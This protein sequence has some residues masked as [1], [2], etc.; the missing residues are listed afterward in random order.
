MSD[1]TGMTLT[2]NGALAYQTSSNPFV[3]F[4]MMFTRGITN[5]TIDKYM[6]LCWQEDPRKAIAIIFQGRDRQNGKKEKNISIRAMIW[7]RKNK[8]KTYQKNIANYIKYGCWKDISYIAMKMPLNHS[9]EIELFAKQLEQ[10]IQKLQNKKY[11]DISLC[12]KWA[13]S[14]KDKYDVSCNLA[15]SIALEL[16]PDNVNV[17]QSYRKEIL[18]PLRKHIN[19]VEAYMTANKWKQIKYENVPAVATKRLRNAFKKHDED[20]YND[21]LKKVASGEKKMKTT[22]ILPHELVNHYLQ[23][24]AYDETIEL[25]WKALVDNVKQQGLLN[26]T[27]P[28][29]DVSGSMMSYGTGNVTPIQ[30]SIALGLLTAEC[31]TG[32]FANKVISFH[33]DPSIHVI[34]GNTLQEK[35]NMIRDIPAGLKTDFEAVFK[36]L[37]N[38]GKT[39]NLSQ[40]QMPE[41]LIVLSDMQFDEASYTGL[42][43]CVLHDTITQKYAAAGYTPPKF[44]YWNLS[45]QHAETFPVKAVSPNVAMISGFSEQL[46]KVFMN[47]D[48][49][50][51]ESVVNEILSKYMLDVSIDDDDI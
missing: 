36:M 15:H 20:G 25:Q 31:T 35:V 16:F 26:A 21:F 1:G 27:I 32:H 18:V 23:N 44:I 49:F 11:K 9:F 8:Y 29:V 7:L 51:P 37:I 17:M 48:N 13:S 28:I 10:D 47:S 40:E 4:F 43:E 46:L 2:T 30:V 14:E 39:F 6:Q 22:G 41:K 5:D 42:N 3:D 50:D 38:A 45:S 34:E 19:I 12:A 33:I 24:K